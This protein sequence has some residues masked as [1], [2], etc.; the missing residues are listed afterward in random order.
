MT[1]EVNKT[2]ARRI[3]SDGMTFR[4]RRTNNRLEV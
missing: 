1:V 3:V 4:N 2:L